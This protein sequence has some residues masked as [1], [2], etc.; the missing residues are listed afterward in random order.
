VSAGADEAQERLVKAV[1]H[2]LRH[3]V[4]AAIDEAGEASPKAVA[5]M[6]DEPLGRVS[7]HVRVL[8]RL[9]AIELVRT[10]P[11]RGVTEHFYRAAVTRFFDDEAAARLP[12]GTR[13][14]VVA[15]Y[16]QRLLGDAAAAA[17]GT[18]FEH[19][20]AHLSYVLLDLDERGMDELAAVLGET[21]ARIQDIKTESAERLGDES[22]PLR[23]EVGILHFERS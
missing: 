13:R 19:P 8:V 18:G 14:Q 3:R 23:T 7:H 4:L 6:L 9:G 2:P 11:R 1:A 22:P 12:R 21:L 10:K 17:A 16:V 20:H 5:A 15:Q